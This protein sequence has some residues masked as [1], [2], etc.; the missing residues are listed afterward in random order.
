MKKKWLS[1]ALILSVVGICLT[2]YSISGY[3]HIRKA[4]LEEVSFCSIN[5]KINCDIINASSYS[6]LFDIPVATWGL[7]F[8][9]TALM[10]VAFIR[11]TKTPR[12]RV[13]SFI[14]ILSILGVLWN[15]RMA[16]VSIAALGAICL[17]CVA[18]YIA[19]LLLALALTF[20]SSSKLKER[21]KLVLSRKILS[22]AMTTA[23]I[24]IIGYVFAL[25][26]VKS[27]VPA[28]SQEDIRDAVNAHFRQSLYDIKPED[29]ENAPTW[30]NP[31]AK[32]AIVE[33]SDFQCPFC[34]VAAFSLRPYLYEFRDRIKFVY[35]NY[36]LDNS[37]NKYLNHPM[38][39]NACL[40]AKASI[41]AQEKGK[42]WEYHDD[43][44]RNQQKI[45]REL[46]V[47][48]AVERGIDKEWM[49]SCLEDPVTLD[50]I[51]A[52]IE[53]AHHIYL[54]GTPS[55]FINQRALRLWRFPEAL[56]ALIREELKRAK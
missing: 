17:T 48:L 24:F 52:D 33:F 2:S 27:A 28:I 1:L 19:S 39:A 45:S 30:G 15:I 11:F 46:L 44:F 41:C 14:W 49:E 34:K 13:L 16:Y 43:I 54:S 29:I 47:N 53:V 18:Q 9:F 20:S 4:G 12:D 38:H 37:C 32:V 55:V 5:E 23:I 51:K 50:K 35:M 8:Y 7:M 21:M 25:S 3:F 42:F 22:L 6:E 56:R 26:A 31:D 40:A 36:P 10:F